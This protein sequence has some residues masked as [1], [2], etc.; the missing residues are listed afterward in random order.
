MLAGHVRVKHYLLTSDTKQHTASSALTMAATVSVY[1]TT[2]PVAS[3]ALAFL[4]T[5]L[6][7][8]LYNTVF[9]PL[10]RFPGPPIAPLTDFY[11]LY[12]FAGNNVHGKL[13]ELHY[14]YGETMPLCGEAY[15]HA[16]IKLRAYCAHCSKPSLSQRSNTASGDLRQKCG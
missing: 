16:L 11:K 3:V 15:K 4:L 10:H 12:L 6:G 13:E 2:S 14:R 8:C 7:F 5:I 9:H 1:L